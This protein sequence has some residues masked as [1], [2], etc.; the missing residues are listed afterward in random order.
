MDMCH[1]ACTALGEGVAQWVFI[2]ASLAWGWWNKRQAS[3]AKAENT[4]LKA[5]MKP[6]APVPVIHYQGAS[7]GLPLAS[8][9]PPKPS[10]YYPPYEPESITSTAPETPSAKERSD[11]P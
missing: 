10:G 9:L 3:A 7:E 5:S 11:A 2:A 8:L 4:Q 1:S 6:P